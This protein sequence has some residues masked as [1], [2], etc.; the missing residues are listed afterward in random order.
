M[1]DNFAIFGVKT[2]FKDNSIISAYKEIKE[3]AKRLQ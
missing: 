2:P 1:N 3:Y